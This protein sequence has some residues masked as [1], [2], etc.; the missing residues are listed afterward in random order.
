MLFC[1]MFPLLVGDKVSEDDSSWKCYLTF[2]DILDI[3]VSP[4]ISEGLCGHLK[5]LIK[6]YLTSFKAT[7]PSASIIPKT[8]YPEQIMAISP[9][10]RAWTMHYEAKLN[11]FKRASHL[12]T[13]KTS[14]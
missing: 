10:I 6:Q 2:I 14:H 5:L 8:H 7:Y 4:I 1:R 11:L 3:V 12:G 13:S 9:P